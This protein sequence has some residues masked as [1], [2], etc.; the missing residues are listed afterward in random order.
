[1]SLFSA[2]VKQR[3]HEGI[4]PWKDIGAANAIPVYA[5]SLL[6]HQ[7]CE[8]GEL[9]INHTSLQQV[10]LV[11]EREVRAINIQQVRGTD[12]RYRVN[13]HSHF[14]TA[15]EKGATTSKILMNDQSGSRVLVKGPYAPTVEAAVSVLERDLAQKLQESIAKPENAA[16]Q[17]WVLGPLTKATGGAD[18]EES[19]LPCTTWAGVNVEVETQEVAH[20]KA[21]GTAPA[22]GGEYVQQF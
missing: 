17:S 4:L 14:H 22:C 11:V 20:S 3:W 12:F 15:S 9:M 5:A 7:P 21:T 6:F 16:D 8:A 10:T 19:R 2:F 18:G 1:M 13:V